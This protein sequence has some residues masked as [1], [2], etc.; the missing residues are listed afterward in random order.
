M[1]K[2]IKKLIMAATNAP[3]I[4]EYLQVWL[5]MRYKMDEATTPAERRALAR[6]QLFAHIDVAIE[7]AEIED[8]RRLWVSDSPEK[9]N[10]VGVRGMLQFHHLSAPEDWGPGRFPIT[11]AMMAYWRQA[12]EQADHIPGGTEWPV[13]AVQFVNYLRECAICEIIV[14][15]QAIAIARKKERII[16]YSA[17]TDSIVSLGFHVASYF[18]CVLTPCLQVLSQRLLIV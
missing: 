14:L 15:P 9:W 12:R 17:P 11:P 5:A 3:L 2:G 8:F 16:S 1:G 4:Q 13:V 10:H 6:R 18:T 7:P